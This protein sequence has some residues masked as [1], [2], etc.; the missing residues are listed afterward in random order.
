MASR[1]TFA[2]WLTNADNLGKQVEI[3]T[4]GARSF[5]VL[6]A[7]L[8]VHQHFVAFTTEIQGTKNVT[9]PI[10]AIA[11]IIRMQ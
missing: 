6:V 1:E 2:E 9:L 7:G 4:T 10:S 5:V 3:G 8:H 11:Y